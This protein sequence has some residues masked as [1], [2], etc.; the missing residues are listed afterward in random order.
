M[1][2]GVDPGASL[3]TVIEAYL[4]PVEEH[5]LQHEDFKKNSSTRG[6]A[7]WYRFN[8]CVFNDEDRVE[9]SRL[10]SK[11][12]KESYCLLHEWWTAAYSD[13]STSLAHVL[14]IIDDC[15]NLESSDDKPGQWNLLLSHLQLKRW[16]TGD[17]EVVDSLQQ[18]NY[19]T[20]LRRLYSTEFGTSTYYGTISSPPL[21]TIEQHRRDASTKAWGQKTAWKSFDFLRYSSAEHIDGNCED[22]EIKTSQHVSSARLAL[23]FQEITAPPI[24]ACSWLKVENMDTRRSLPHY[25]WDRAR[26]CTIPSANLTGIPK[27]T[28]ISHTWGRWIKPEKRACVSGV[29]WLIPENTR[30]EVRDLPSLLLSVPGG[31]AYLWLDLLCIPQDGTAIATQE[32]A[33]QAEIFKGAERAVAWL[34]DVPDFDCLTTA[35]Q[36]HLLKTPSLP[37]GSVRC[38]IRDRLLVTLFDRLEDRASNLLLPRKGRLTRLLTR[39]N[40]F[41]TSLWT[42][43]ELCL[44]PEMW[45][46]ATDW[47]LLSLDGVNPLPISGI[48]AIK[49][50]YNSLGRDL[51]PLMP[52]DHR[53][54]KCIAIWEIGYWL[55][56]TGLARLR[57]FSR[58][59]IIAWADQRQCTSRRAEAIMSALGTTEWYAEASSVDFEVNLVL[60]KYPLAFVREVMA[61]NPGEFFG[62]F[63]KTSSTTFDDNGLIVQKNEDSE[64]DDASDIDDEQMFR[65]RSS[66]ETLPNLMLPFSRYAAVYIDGRVFGNRAFVSHDSLHTW[67][68]LPSGYVQMPRACVLASSDPR[69]IPPTNAKIRANFLGFRSRNAPTIDG[70]LFDTAS[71]EGEINDWDVDLQEWA[72]SRTYEVYTVVLSFSNVI[73]Y[74]GDGDLAEEV[75][76]R[77]VQGFILRRVDDRHLWKMGNFYASDIDSQL[78]LPEA[79]DVDWLAF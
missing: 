75:S 60:G 55:N 43:Q 71:P 26:A 37:R 70:R 51:A 32:I 57:D 34:N 14:A 9:F 24:S 48:P 8:Y 22:V 25:L 3:G 77:Q 29:P 66:V 68:I 31:S 10:L 40:S 1:S 23:E 30:F 52:L 35:L 47:R 41:W 2:L 65:R 63:F 50:A 12:Q 67:N 49:E 19:D 45:L 33:R 69:F 72:R 64:D 59:D 4:G 15:Q 20:V 53:Q 56:T 76:L 74:S 36:W 7:N 58:A 39:P 42:L 73:F 17:I 11:Q 61:Q 18:Q 62:S 46:A 13:E 5:L 16:P 6:L 54:Q 44:R 79:R 38:E 27:Y 21:P 78:T 28:A